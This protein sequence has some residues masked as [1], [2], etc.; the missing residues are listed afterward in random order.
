MSGAVPNDETDKMCV[1]WLSR[2]T[3]HDTGFSLFEVMTALAIL[4]LVSSSVLVVIDRCVI[5]ATDSALRMDAFK[6]ARENME[7]ILAAD[8]VTETVE[9]GTSDAYGD[10]AWQTVVEAFPEPATGNMWIRAISSAEYVDSAGETQTVELEHWIAELTDQQ[11]DQL[12]GQQDLDELA[13][14]QLVE[15]LEDAAEYAG[16]DVETFKQWV[17]NGMLTT[18]DGAFIRY[19]IDFY[20]RSNGDPSAEDRARQVESIEELAMSLRTRG[21]EQDPTSGSRQGADGIDPTT[22]LPYEKL[23]QM[24]IGEVIEL[25]KDRQK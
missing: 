3:F 11:A 21:Q 24:E 17:E 9:Y 12:A 5:S 23:E 18:E 16:V 2:G 13:A 15:T 1:W 4:A 10:M 19:N 14:E 22:G 25:L 7:E 6:L 20:V 8:S